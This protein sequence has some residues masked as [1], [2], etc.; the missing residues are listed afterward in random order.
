M[1]ESSDQEL[2]NALFLAQYQAAREV[3]LHARQIQHSVVSW[4]TAAAGVLVG[5]GAVLAGRGADAVTAGTSGLAFLLLFTIALPGL[6]AVSFNSWI[7]EVARMRRAAHFLRDIEYTVHRATLPGWPP[8]PTYD[9][10]VSYGPDGSGDSVTKI[11]RFAVAAL[12][13][14]L[15]AVSVIV[16]SASLWNFDV[17]GYRLL[18]R[19]IGQ[20]VLV[21]S[22]VWF[23]AAVRHGFTTLKPYA[24]HVMTYID[25]DH[26]V[27]KFG[28]RDRHKS[29]ADVSSLA[30]PAQIE[31]ASQHGSC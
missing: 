2:R 21:G 7:G 5:S 19:I 12:H 17:D 9:T 4:S 26:L 13:C 1:S 31:D 18:V 10:D 20:G 3:V 22:L 16:A 25:E 24:S 29:D 8:T 27:E 11:G 23:F 14:G 15:F 30:K 6:I 28:P